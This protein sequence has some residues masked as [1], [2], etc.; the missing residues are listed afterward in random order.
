MED[1]KLALD[2]KTGEV[3]YNTRI[4][5]SGTILREPMKLP[6][7]KIELCYLLDKVESITKEG[8]DRL[9]SLADK[10]LFSNT[11]NVNSYATSSI[12]TMTKNLKSL[13][14]KAQLEEM[15]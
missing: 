11:I 14:S 2:P 12:T 5:N 4:D 13:L 6:V 8:L 15:Y 9:Q 3:V 10:H 1:T 7:K